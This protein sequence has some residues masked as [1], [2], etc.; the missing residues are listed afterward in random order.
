MHPVPEQVPV[1]V[2]A[3]GGVGRPAPDLRVE[4]AAAAARAVH[5]LEPRGGRVRREVGHHV[6]RAADGVPHP[7]ESTGAGEPGHRR[8]EPGVEP[9]GEVVGGV[10]APGGARLRGDPH[11][12]HAPD[13][14]HV[15]DAE[16]PGAQAVQRLDVP[17]V[18]GQQVGVEGRHL[19]R[20]PVALPQEREQVVAAVADE[21]ER[22]GQQ[23][24]DRRRR[25]RRAVAIAAAVRHHL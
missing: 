19:A 1:A 14:R 23:I 16:P 12:R 17:R 20:R 13:G 22:L 7:R 2:A 24:V 18:V 8:P 11:R 9:P 4:P 21:E 25:R 15:D 5:H 6:V 3:V 10:D